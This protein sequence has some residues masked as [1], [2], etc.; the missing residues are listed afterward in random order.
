ME[1]FDIIGLRPLMERTKGRPEITVAVID[2]P[3]ALHHP[4]LEGQRIQEIRG[5][6][7]RCHNRD[8]FACAHGTFVVGMLAAKRA[9][10]APGICP[11]CS[12]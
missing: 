4:D 2:G 10:V 11:E 3:V 6:A 8:S 12:F 5:N 9:S 7:A 1:P